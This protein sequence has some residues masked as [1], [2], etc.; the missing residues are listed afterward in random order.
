MKIKLNPII[1]QSIVLLL[2]LNSCGEYLNRHPVLA[3]MYNTK[4]YFKEYDPPLQLQLQTD[5][6]QN[7]KYGIDSLDIDLDGRFDLRIGHRINL[8]WNY[9]K[10]MQSL[11]ENN[12]PSCWLEPG[13]GFAIAVDLIYFPLGHGVV[14]SWS[15]VDTIQYKCKIDGLDNWK[16]L[17]NK[18]Y[19]WAIPPTFYTR[20]YGFWYYLN[21]KE[22][23]IGIRQNTGGTYKYGWIKIKMYTHDD[24]EILSYAMQK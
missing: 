19:M 10:D 11:D 23:Y 18:V 1:L 17:N 20:G 2:L 12:F 9:S 3:G 15:C 14:S 22:M 6:I 24:F 13:S 16:G 5:T 4:M 21:N 7:I 8:T